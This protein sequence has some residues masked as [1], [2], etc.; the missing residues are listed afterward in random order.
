MEEED[1]KT[2]TKYMAAKQGA[3]QAECIQ[4]LPIEESKEGKQMKRKREE[5]EVDEKKKKKTKS[6]K[7]KVTATTDN[8]SADGEPS[9]MQP[10]ATIPDWLRVFD[11]DK[12]ISAFTLRE[13]YRQND[14]SRER[15]AKLPILGMLNSPGVEEF[16]NRVVNYRMLQ[17]GSRLL[18]SKNQSITTDVYNYWVCLTN[19]NKAWFKTSSDREK[20]QAE[21]DEQEKEKE[22]QQQLD[23]LREGE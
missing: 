2:K 12:L 10:A 1:N 14:T 19:T 17:Q 3:R 16:N 9:I 20:Y 5:M 23:N 4:L 6:K 22:Q 15:L 13:A 21:R 11:S 7:R 8:K 18:D